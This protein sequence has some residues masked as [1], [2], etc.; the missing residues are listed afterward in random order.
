MKL[1]RSFSLLLLLLTGVPGLAGDWQVMKSPNLGTQANSLSSVSAVT[2]S[3]VW[4]V[5]WGWSQSLN[6]YRTVIEHWNGARWSLVTSPNATNGYNLLN[7]VAAVASNDVWAVGQAAIG[8]TYSTL[9]EHWN[10][11]AWSI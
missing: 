8:S 4:T 2:D 7:G 10:G 9:V 3:D 6:A 1:S 11:S 5:G